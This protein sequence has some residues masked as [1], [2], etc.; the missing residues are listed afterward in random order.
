[1]EGDLPCGEDQWKRVTRM[2]NVFV[3]LVKGAQFP[4]CS[5]GIRAPWG[6][7]Y[8]LQ[9]SAIG[10]F[11]PTAIVAV[12][13]GQYVS[14][15]VLLMTLLTSLIVHRESRTP[16][17]DVFDQVDEVC[18]ALWAA[19]NLW[20]W[21]RLAQRALIPVMMMFVVLAIDATRRRL[22]W[23]SPLR[24]TVHV[25]MHMA[26]ALGTVILLLAVSDSNRGTIPVTH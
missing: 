22:P 3:R 12:S 2:H 11:V 10:S 17:R 6:P 9:V 7:M 4:R 16:A 24:V 15:G 25:L 23:R 1:M 18:I 13:L 14:A 8:V 19:H 5:Q 21:E 20:I 26:G